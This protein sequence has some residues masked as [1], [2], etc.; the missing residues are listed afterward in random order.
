[1]SETKVLVT[2][3]SG[4]VGGRV[5]ERLALERTDS[6]RAMVRSWTRAARVAKFPI[7]IAAADIMRP[8]QVAA[9]VK[10]VTHV[11]H[12][13]YSDN[14]DVIIEGTRNLL[15]AALDNGLRG[16]VYLSTAEVYGSQAEGTIDETAPVQHTGRAYAD[17]KI[18]AENVCRE[19]HSRGLPVTILR[20]S[21]VYGPFG[22]SWTIEIAKRLQSGHW[23]EFDNYGEGFCNVVYVDDLVSAIMLAAQYSS[24]AATAFN[25]NGPEVGTWNEYFRKFNSILELPPLE[26]K[27]AGRSALRSAVIDRLD[28][29]AGTIV[30]RFEDRLMEIYLRGGAASRLM[31]RVKTVLNSTPSARELEDLYS[32]RAVYSDRRARE[33]LGYSPRIDLQS[34]LTTSAQWLAYHGFIESPPKDY[35]ASPEAMEYRHS[36]SNQV[37]ETVSA[38]N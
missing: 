24:A 21:I 2:G 27:S 17:A 25:I 37:S 23:C 26:T 6:V 12:T 10:G 19:F 8:Q 13:A 38:A 28:R 14:P 1:M 29:I 9:A 7:E 11:V 32:R 33:Y 31:K 4:F 18:E 20:P 22:K 34:G 35:Y 5:V 3:A 15:A 16:F 30:S 36:V